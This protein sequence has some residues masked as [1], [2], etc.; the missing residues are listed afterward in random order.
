MIVR[1][2]PYELMQAATAGC[3]RQISALAR[4]LPDRHG[5][6]GL[7]WS[8]HIEGA[9][10]EMAVGK[11]T[12]RYVSGSINTFKTG[13]DLGS[14]VQVRTR[15]RHDYDL[16]V[17]RDDRDDDAFVLVTGRSPSFQVR[18]WIWGRDAKQERWRATHGNREPAFFVPAS[19]LACIDTMPQG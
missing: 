15:S 11:A 19:D 12:G 16:I 1:L 18:G 8:E 6:V 7:G 4:S 3:L 2:T 17:R 14:R 13:G 10:G 9:C 5:F